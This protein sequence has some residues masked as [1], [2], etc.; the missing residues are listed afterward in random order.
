MTDILL[1]D[2]NPIQFG[3][4]DKKSVPCASR[5]SS[6]SEA[7]WAKK[8]TVG[9]ASETRPKHVGIMFGVCLDYYYYYYYYDG[10]DGDD[11]DD[12]GLWL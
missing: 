3:E 2:I 12:G 5:A 7:G 10:N 11:D 9:N 4:F 8:F 1:L 6:K